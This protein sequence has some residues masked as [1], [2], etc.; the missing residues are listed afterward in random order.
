MDGH[1]DESCAGLVGGLHTPDC[2]VGD[3]RWDTDSATQVVEWLAVTECSFTPP[4][5]RVCLSV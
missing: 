2:L 1:R 5:K 4:A 3:R